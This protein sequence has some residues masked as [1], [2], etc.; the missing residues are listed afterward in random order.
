MRRGR[1]I[2]LEGGEGTGKS[3]QVRRLASWIEGAF[4]TQVVATREPGG[5]PGAE[6]I[7]ALLVD[8]EPD[9][10]DPVTEVLLHFA[11]RRTHVLETV[12]PALETGR[13]VVS[14][15]FTDSTRAY[16]GLVQGAGLDL[17]EEIAGLA[18]ATP[19]PDL[20]FVLDLPAGQGLERAAS[21]GG[22]DRYERMGRAFHERLREAYLEIARG[23]PE[24]IVVVDA[25]GSEE[26]VAGCL[27]GEVSRRWPP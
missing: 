20:T 14:D 7:R 19:L 18:V 1:F 8:G 4:G 3:T 23:D 22:G 10:W 11:A 21:R 9:R 26:D 24:R 6:S 12:G 2:T 13:W 16:Q 15:R 5:A 25:S 17:V 27:A